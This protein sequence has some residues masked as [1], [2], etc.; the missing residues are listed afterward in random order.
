MN[1]VP[2]RVASSERRQVA[3]DQLVERKLERVGSPEDEPEDAE[4]DAADDP[5]P[6]DPVEAPLE[7]RVRCAPPE[8]EQPERKPADEQREPHEVAPLGDVLE[9]RRPTRRRT[10]RS[11]A[12]GLDA[13]AEGVDTGDHVTLVGGDVPAHGVGALR[14]LAQ[15]KTTCGRYPSWCAGPAVTSLPGRAPHLDR[16]RERRRRAWSNWSDT[17]AEQRRAGRRRSAHARAGRRERALRSAARA[18]RGPRRRSA[19]ALIARRR[20]GTGGRRSA[21]RSGRRRGAWPW[22]GS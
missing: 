12:A 15:R 21:R 1:A 2:N 7:C 17:S 18:R 3:V 4:L 22:R 6:D 5:G 13:D 10:P 14:K 9:L 11:A 19:F 8:D 20:A 16:V